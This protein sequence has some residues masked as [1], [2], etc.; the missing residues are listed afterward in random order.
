MPRTT[1]TRLPAERF[2]Y[3]PRSRKTTGRAWAHSTPERPCGPDGERVGGDGVNRES[4]SHPVVVGTP[5]GR[6]ENEY[7]ALMQAAPFEEPLD[8]SSELDESMARV[9]AMLALLPDRERLAMT[10][11]I[12]ERRTLREAATVM[13]VSKSQ[14]DRY[15]KRGLGTLADLLGGELPSDDVQ[16]ALVNL[17][18][19]DPP[20][21]GGYLGG[22]RSAPLEPAEAPV[23]MADEWAQYEQ[24][25]ARLRAGTAV[26]VDLDLMTSFE[27]RVGLGSSFSP[28][29]K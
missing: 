1:F 19:D 25:Q 4:R 22:D 10:L 15:L 29:W 23:V 21:L 8:S 24:A 28:A 6:P 26:G 14:V 11:V 5:A 12:L 3:A 9:D 18:P 17:A 2:E 20:E 16:A 7:E 27:K 13:G